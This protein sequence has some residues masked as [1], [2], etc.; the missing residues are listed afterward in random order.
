MS[1]EKVQ[2]MARVIR[3]VRV[4]VIAVDGIDG[5]TTG[6]VLGSYAR[7]LF[8]DVNNKRTVVADKHNKRCRGVVE[9]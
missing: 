4:H 5:D 6:A 1:G 3:W 8:T 9:Q 2:N 7:E